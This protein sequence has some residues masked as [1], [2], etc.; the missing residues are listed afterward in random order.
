M[1]RSK[2]GQF[3]LWV[4]RATF[5]LIDKGE[6][7]LLVRSEHWRPCGL[8]VGDVVAIRATIEK[9]E[10]GELL[11]SICAVRRYRQMTQ[12]VNHEDLARLAHG[13]AVQTLSYL[14]RIYRLE[15]EEG[16]A[17]VFELEPLLMEE[18]K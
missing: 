8:R 13:N 14:A 9:G 16:E 7:N 18:K 1:P 2:T 4:S 11:R 12:I 5:R 6:K 10:T 17:V 15:Q 3:I